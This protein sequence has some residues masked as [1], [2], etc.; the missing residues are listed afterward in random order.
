MTIV[1]KTYIFSSMDRNIRLLVE[2][3]IYFKKIFCEHY[4]FRD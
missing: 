4:P 1:N 2:S 3:S